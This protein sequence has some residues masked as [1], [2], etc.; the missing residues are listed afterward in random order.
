MGSLLV[1]FLLLTL[2][3]SSPLARRQAVTD[4]I[5]PA[6]PPPPGCSPVFDGIFGVAVQNLTDGNDALDKRKNPIRRGE[7]TT[8][9][10]TSRRCT[11]EDEAKPA[12]A[13]LPPMTVAQINQIADGQIQGSL[14][15]VTMNP[16]DQIADGQIQNHRVTY[17]PA[18]Y[19]PPTATATPAVATDSDLAAIS[20]TTASPTSAG[21]DDLDPSDPTNDNDNDNDIAMV[22]CLTDSSLQLQLSDGILTDAY[23]RTGYIASNYQFQFDAPPQ[24]EA[25]FTSGWSVCG[26]GSL[27][28][29]GSTVFWQCLSGDFYNLYDRWWASQCSEVVIRVVELVDCGTEG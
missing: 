29:G 20:Q 14:H 17:A 6:A 12:S 1:P 19:V 16:I 27:A 3:S 8:K 2:A 18:A 11:C 23:A 5:A 24:A 25:L 15:T 4:A 13:T 21:S 28:L 7:C 9:T 22:A 26:N 10:R